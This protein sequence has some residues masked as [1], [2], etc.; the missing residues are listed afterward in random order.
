MS[1]SEDSSPP[2]HGAFFGRRK[3]HPLRSHQAALMQTLLPRLAL[4]RTT[5]APADLAALFPHSVERVRLE[6]GFGGGE[7]LA[8]QAR[9]HP[10]AGF[11]GCE[12]FVNGMAKMLAAME[13]QPLH[14]IPRH[15]G[16][17]VELSAWSPDAALPRIDILPA[18]PWPK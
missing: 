5:P 13:V 18:S 17:A 12:P 8:A 1:N 6:I 2:R 4:D 7:H 9:A 16:D 11:I 14:N 3:G 15:F 10:N